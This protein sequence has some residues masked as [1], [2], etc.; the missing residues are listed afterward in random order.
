MSIEVGKAAE[1]LVLAD[2]LLQKYRAFPTDQGLPYDIVV[3]ISGRL[4]RIQ[5]KA[6][7]QPRPVPHR[8]GSGQSYFFYCRRA[9]KAGARAVPN[10][11]FDILAL[12]A[13]DIRT[14]AYVPLN[15]TVPQTLHLR[16][17]GHRSGHG[18]KWRGDIDQMPFR[19][20]LCTVLN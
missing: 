18:N 11:T 12:V 15:S 7:Q 5:V 6:T 13:L 9:G 20:A 10:G 14:I 17:P 4:I 8:P 2:L 16:A 3:D 1:Y 19:E